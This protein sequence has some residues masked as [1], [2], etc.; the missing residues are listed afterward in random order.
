MTDSEL[1]MLCKYIRAVD[2]HVNGGL[3]KLARGQVK[4]SMYINVLI[5][6]MM[7]IRFEDRFHTTTDYR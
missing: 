1:E 2:L 6:F 5:Q 3:S 7:K 4:I